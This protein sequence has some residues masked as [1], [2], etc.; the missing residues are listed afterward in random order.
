MQYD[1]VLSGLRILDFKPGALFLNVGVFHSEVRDK[2]KNDP[3]SRKKW[4][5]FKNTALITAK[6][7]KT[8]LMASNS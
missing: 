6:I 4:R 2:V 5:I 8:M 3:Q 7:R 1:N